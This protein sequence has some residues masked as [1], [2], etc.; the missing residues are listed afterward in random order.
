M[1]PKVTFCQCLKFENIHRHLKRVNRPLKLLT[2]RKA[3]K[4]N[5]NSTTIGPSFIQLLKD[6]PM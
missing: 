3:T 4:L 6:T 1:P 2:W 5:E